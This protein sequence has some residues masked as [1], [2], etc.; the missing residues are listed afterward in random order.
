MFNKRGAFIISCLLVAVCY[1]NSLPNDFIFDDAPIV[2]SN[3][4]IRAIS[5]VQFLKSPYW[6]QQQYAGIYRPL[7]LF[8]LSIDYALWKRWAPGFRLVNLVL[9]AINGFLVFSICE[10]L[11]GFGIVPFLAMVFYVVH[12]IHTE[13]VTTI[14]GRS[15]L[16]AACFFFAAWLLFRR[17]HSIWASF[18]FFLALLSKENAIVL[19]AILLLDMWFFASLKG[20]GAEREP[21]RAKPQENSAAAPSPR[22][23]GW[24]RLI[25]IGLV[26]VAYL[27]LRFYVLGAVGIPT[28]AQY[29]AGRLNYFDRLLTS[30]RVF[31]KYLIIIFYPLNLSGD[32][33]FNAIPIARVTD[34]DAWTGLFL[35]VAAIL[36]ITYIYRRGNRL[37][38]FGLSFAVVVFIPSSNWV[39]P[40][41]VLMAERFLYL[42]M[43]GLAFAAAVCFSVIKDQRLRRLT[44]IGFL[45]IAIVIC[46]GHNYIRRDDFTFFKNMVRVVP[47][48]AKARLGYGFALIK[49]GRNDEAV[50]QLE[51]GLQIIPDFPELLSTLALA[52]MTSTSCVDAWPLLQRAIQIDPDHAD[53]QRRM[54]DCYFKEGRIREAESMYRQAAQ[55]IPNPDAMLYFMWGRSLEI[56]GENARAVTAYDRAALIEPENAFIQQRL[57]ALGENQS[58]SE[59][60]Q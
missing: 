47:D 15:E 1:L 44:G 22:G 3:P 56:I 18:M 35:I 7:V 10:S 59:A 21:D 17:G 60:H 45:L 58:A 5:P 29:M 31:I 39:M 27:A 25:P 11:V 16:F 26:A 32:Y 51:A 46:N 42:P 55:S 4:A 34:W 12:P 36:A 54:G 50:Q 53:T 48:S 52:K 8:S 6:T 30:G 40:I 49:A 38:A 28:S 13:A 33:D 57:S 43:A 37:L 9:H 14:V 41:G 2:S 24:S 23:R 20:R 19:P